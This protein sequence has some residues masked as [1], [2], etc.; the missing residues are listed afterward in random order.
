MFKRGTLFVELGD[1]NALGEQCAKV[2]LGMY[3]PET[4]G[5]IVYDFE[6]FFNLAVYA[7]RTMLAIKEE[8]ARQAETGSC[9]LTLNMLAMR[10]LECNA[11][12]LSNIQH[13]ADLLAAYSLYAKNCFVVQMM[14]HARSLLARTLRNQ[15]VYFIDCQGVRCINIYDYKYF[16]YKKSMRTV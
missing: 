3:S 8:I 5:T 12:K 15:R 9:S 16:F 2:C 10:L 11:D 6:D 13:D 1:P 14:P 7:K 4:H